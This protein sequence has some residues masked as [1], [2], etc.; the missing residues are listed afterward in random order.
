MLMFLKKIILYF[1]VLMDM[2]FFRLGYLV[3]CFEVEGRRRFFGE[4]NILGVKNFV[5]VVFVGVIC[6]EG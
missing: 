6:F 3:E 5:L 1:S 4:V 2:S